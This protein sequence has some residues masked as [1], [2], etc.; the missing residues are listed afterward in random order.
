MPTGEIL[1][2]W[3]KQAQVMEHATGVNDCKKKKNA[4]SS[5]HNR[6]SIIL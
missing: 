5:A 3:R 2:L 1:R 6:K 4:S